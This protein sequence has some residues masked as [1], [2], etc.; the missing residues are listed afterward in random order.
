MQPTHITVPY[1]DAV[2]EAPVRIGWCRATDAL[3]H[4][5]VPIL[6]GWKGSADVDAPTTTSL[7]QIDG[8][9]VQSALNYVMASSTSDGLAL[10]TF[11]HSPVSMLSTE[12]SLDVSLAESTLKLPSHAFANRRVRGGEGR[13]NLSS[14][15]R[16]LARAATPVSEMTL[17]YP[18]PRDHLHKADCSISVLVAGPEGS[19]KPYS[20]TLVDAHTGVENRAGLVFGPENDTWIR[21]GG[22]PT[23]LIARIATD[24]AEQVQRLLAAK[25]YATDR[26][27]ITQRAVAAELTKCLGGDI[28]GCRE[29]SV[30]VHPGVAKGPVAI[31]RLVMVRPKY[32][33]AMGKSANSLVVPCVF[34]MMSEGQMQKLM[35]TPTMWGGGMLM[36]P[37][38]SDK[39]KREHNLPDHATTLSMQVIEAPHQKRHPCSNAFPGAADLSV[40]SKSGTHGRMVL[41][42]D[43]DCPRS[44]P[45]SVDS[46]ILPVLS[47]GAEVNTR[48]GRIDSVFDLKVLGDYVCGVDKTTR[49]LVVTAN[50]VLGDTHSQTTVD[51]AK[52][53]QSMRTAEA[54]VDAYQ[55]AAFTSSSDIRIAPHVKR[56]V[57]GVHTLANATSA[58]HNL[59]TVVEQ[60]VDSP[61]TVAPRQKAARAMET[62]R[63]TIMSLHSASPKHNMVS[64]LVPAQH[65]RALGTVHDVLPIAVERFNRATHNRAVLL[66][67][68]TVDGTQRDLTVLFPD[69]DTAGDH[70]YFSSAPNMQ[71]E[72]LYT[73]SSVRHALGMETASNFNVVAMRAQPICGAQPFHTEKAHNL[74]GRQYA[75]FAV[76]WRLGR[77]AVQTDTFMVSTANRLKSDE[78]SSHPVGRIVTVD[79]PTGKIATYNSNWRIRRV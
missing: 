6:F 74:D 57:D 3:Q 19:D 79:S 40:Y 13:S 25:T 26:T 63:E 36:E 66:V 34:T 12:D 48:C 22:C 23:I 29:S 73:A 30:I 44:T 42:E 59:H 43:I 72:Q 14:K 32:H 47:A 77:E 17:S 33:Q 60:I 18:S 7:M 70:E 64:M 8:G 53:E 39:A 45:W 5:Q 37:V 46:H 67:D 31:S 54:A 49:Q 71:A 24:A 28:F 51:P 50:K 56:Y 4:V 38:S 16:K 21:N 2:C 20:A 11:M 76:D 75:C 15:L 1:D 41:T 27:N 58:L 9:Y 52:I 65:T 55:L 68:H 62:A 69:R 61:G 78:G 10:R 35:Q